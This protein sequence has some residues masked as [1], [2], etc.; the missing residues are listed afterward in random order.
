MV[1]KITT[2]KHTWTSNTLVR[3]IFA[4]RLTFTLSI[5]HTLKDNE[6]RAAAE[7]MMQVKRM[8]RRL[9]R[10]DRKKGLKETER[11][12]ERKKGLFTEGR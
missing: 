9:L 7:R 1:S 2:E 5:L 8:K 11:D 3:S 6:C 12:L 4:V 10:A